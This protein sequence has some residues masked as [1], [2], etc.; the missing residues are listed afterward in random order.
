MGWFLKKFWFLVVSVATLV[1]IFYIPIDTISADEAAAPWLRF[2]AMFDQN[3]ALWLF[4]ILALCYIIWMDAR[5]YV[6]SLLRSKHIKAVRIETNCVK[7]DLDGAEYWENQFYLLIT[8]T[9]PDGET[10]LDVRAKI[11]TLAG[12]RAAKFRDGEERTDLH[13]GESA[14]IYLGSS[15]TSHIVSRPD[16]DAKPR[17]QNEWLRMLVTNLNEHQHKMLLVDKVG[18]S[19]I[20]S[21]K[22][23]ESSDNYFTVQILANGQKPMSFNCIVGA[24]D[25]EA[26]MYL[27]DP[28]ALDRQPRKPTGKIGN[29]Q[30]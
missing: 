9:R 10:L 24:S 11:F 29:T 3:T 6:T 21:G 2:L 20:L 8:N 22:I 4:S 30:R 26:D 23:H 25:G 19:P 14:R 1:G 7:I 17:L 5:P 27:G 18:F 28:K 12:E 16:F 15:I 13:C